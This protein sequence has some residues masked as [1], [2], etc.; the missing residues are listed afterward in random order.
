MVDAADP[1]SGSFLLPDLDDDGGGAPAP[2]R[3]RSG[4]K[5]GNNFDFYTVAPG[6]G[7]KAGL[8]ASADWIYRCTD[9]SGND[10]V[11]RAN[12][13]THTTKGHDDRASAVDFLRNLV[14]E[15]R[16]LRLADPDNDDPLF[17]PPR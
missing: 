9:G 14:A 17:R 13:Q 5:K 4:K 7:R 8:Y 10:I 12:K 2:K 1:G 15:Y 6:G 16:R 3:S 11:T